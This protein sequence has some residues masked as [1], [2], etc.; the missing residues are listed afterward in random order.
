M[1]TR[2]S[3]DGLSCR[4]SHTHL[5]MPVSK[6]SAVGQGKAFDL[7][8]DLTSTSLISR[9]VPPLLRRIV[10]VQLISKIAAVNGGNL[11]H[12]P[13]FFIIKQWNALVIQYI[14]TL[15]RKK[16]PRYGLVHFLDFWFRTGILKKPS[17]L[18]L[19]ILNIP[20]SEGGKLVKVILNSFTLW[21][22]S[23]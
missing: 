14:F 10:C 21:I 8:M 23:T 18:S 11:G 13:Y 15:N 9:V 6:R 3:L 16:N 7:N 4:G 17:S 22:I 1:C 19:T 5:I 2:I 12:Y 20:I